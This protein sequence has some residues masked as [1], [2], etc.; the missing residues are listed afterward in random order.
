MVDQVVCES[1]DT[2]E[3]VNRLVIADLSVSSYLVYPIVCTIADKICAIAQ[4]HP[5]NR[6]SSRVKDLVDLVVILNTQTFEATSLRKQIDL[7]YALRKMGVFER[8]AIPKAW[9]G[10]PYS[11]QYRALYRETQK[12]AGYPSIESAEEL[13][14]GCL[15]GLHGNLR[16]SWNSESLTWT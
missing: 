13:V 3:P 15:D 7:E 4:Q 5:E 2:I 10:Q 8:F 9:Y 1:P 6:P 12:A 14:C 16:A 11:Q